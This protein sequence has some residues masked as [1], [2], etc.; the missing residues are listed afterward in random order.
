M[1]YQNEFDSIPAPLPYD[2]DRQKSFTDYEIANPSDPISGNDLDVEFNAVE[3]ALDETQARLRLIQ[4]DDGA[5]LNAS[6]GLDQLKDEALIGVNAPTTWA[7]FTAYAASDTVIFANAWYVCI[8]AHTSSDDFAAD[9][10][11][12]YWRQLIDLTPFTTEAK[13]WANYPEDSLV[14]EGDGVDDYS[15]LHHAAKALASQVAAASSETDAQTA[16]TAAE[17]A[18]DKSQAWAETAEDVEVETGQ[19]SSLHHKAKAQAAQTAAETAQSGAETAEANAQ[20]AQSGAEAAETGAE[21]AR[22]G[23]ETAE[24]NAAASYDNFDDRYLGAKASDPTLDNDGD[25]LLD[26]ALYWNTTTPEMRV[27]DLGTTSWEPAGNISKAVQSQAE[28]G[29]DNSAYMTPLRTAQAINAIPRKN[30]IING[31]APFVNQEGDKTGAST[32]DYA[33]DIWRLTA[34]A[35][36]V[37]TINLNVSTVGN[38]DWVAVNTTAGDG[39]MNVGDLYLLQYRMEGYDAAPLKLGASDAK[40]VTFS[41]KHRHFDTGTYCVQLRNQ[42]DN[43]EYIFEYEQSVSDAEETHEEI[44][45]L[46][47]T[48]TWVVDNTEGLEINFAIATGTDWETSPSNVQTWG[49]YGAFATTN[50]TNGVSSSNSLFLLR[51][52]QLEI[53]SVATD[54]EYIPYS[55]KL[56][57]VQRYVYRVNGYATDFKFLGHAT[58]QE[59]IQYRAGVTFP[60]VMRDIPTLESFATRIITAAGTTYVPDSSPTIYNASEQATGILFPLSTAPTSNRAA[61]FFLADSTSAFIQFDARL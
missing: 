12:G 18:R 10:A 32:G 36:N 33:A 1:S 30:F 46:D 47:T 14:P 2:Y 3:R 49:A 9:D 26:G 56:A 21:T 40:T 5:I 38:D 13:N 34:D 45:D 25:A 24:A 52:I 53:G 17:A 39:T 57:Q 8:E 20:T 28:T 4:R 16:Q 22:A 44:I 51:D 19:F 29:T 43:R 37:A 31:V 54:P 42:A 41:F 35:L 60:V 61:L 7:E 11:L 6:V 15:A 55:E 48:G 58:S 59:T 27:Y 23:A 50:Q